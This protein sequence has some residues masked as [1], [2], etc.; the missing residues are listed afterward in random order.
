MK[1][2]VLMPVLCALVFFLFGFWFGHPNKV[3]TKNPHQHWAITI[4][5]GEHEVVGAALSDRNYE[6]GISTT[7]IYSSDDNLIYDEYRPNYII[8]SQVLS[9]RRAS[10]FFEKHKAIWIGPDYAPNKPEKETP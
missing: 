4:M 1:N 2:D 3:V 10:E 5:T 6:T 8:Q 9:D 7:Q